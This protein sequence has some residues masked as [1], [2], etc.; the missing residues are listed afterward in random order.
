MIATA[1]AMITAVGHFC[2]REGY[3]CDGVLPVV[4]KC[5]MLLH[6]VECISFNYVNAC[7]CA[8]AFVYAFTSDSIVKYITLLLLS[9][10]QDY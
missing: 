4:R 8:L 2:D 7:T 6:Y 10:L 1:T 9:L 3:S 5:D